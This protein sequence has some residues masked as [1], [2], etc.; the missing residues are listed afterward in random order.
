MN[1]HAVIK[2]YFEQ[3][4]LGPEASA[5]YL[6]L[7]SH[8]PLTMSELARR[9]GIERTRIYRLLENPISQQ[10]IVTDNS[11]K[12][13]LYRSAPLSNLHHVLNSR[14]QAISHLRDNLELIQHVL[15]DKRITTPTDDITAIS[16][17]D[18]I[19]HIWWS[20]L[21]SQTIITGYQDAQLA[22]LLGQ[23]FLQEWAIHFQNRRLKAKLHIN[24][25]THIRET[26]H[27]SGCNYNTIS[28]DTFP[29]HQ[30]CVIWDDNVAII[31]WSQNQAFA[32]VHRNLEYA[33]AHRIW[34]A[35][36]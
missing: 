16:Q 31:S 6:T 24:D 11:T 9:S 35:G 23:A 34:M 17:P 12:K 18:G 10:I 13:G 32:V 8:G 4:G 21:E 2:E 1:P 7:V 29:I 27:I 25:P 19:R 28:A 26:P 3:I 14:M 5:L 30:S 15:G 33:R 22:P 20:L 36:L